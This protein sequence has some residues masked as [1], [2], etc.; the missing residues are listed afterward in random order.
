MACDLGKRGRHRLLNEIYKKNQNF[1]HNILQKNYQKE[2]IKDSDYFCYPIS[3]LSS[4]CLWSKIR[5]Y[6]CWL[7]ITGKFPS[8]YR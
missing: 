4:M 5:L 2:A 7:V 6:Y 1:I 3:E 8:N